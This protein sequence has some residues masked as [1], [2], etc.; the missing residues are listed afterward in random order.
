VNGAKIAALGVKVR[1]WITMHGMAINVNAESLDAFEGIIPCGIMDCRTC[2][3]NNFA[4]KPIS[5]EEF[6]SQIEKSMADIF[7]VKVNRI[8]D[9]NDA[10]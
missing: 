9:M 6:A 10:V 8:N 7:L 5:I 4:Q 2:C 1:R 3:V